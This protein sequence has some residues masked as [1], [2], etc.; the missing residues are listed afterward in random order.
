MADLIQPKTLAASA[1]ILSQSRR[2]HRLHH[3]KRKDNNS[4]I[5]W[6]Q[7]HR[8][9]GPHLERLLCLRQAAGGVGGDL[10]IGEDR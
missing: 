5:N 3:P 8:R 6:V 10:K 9:E 4:S 1:L 7:G 2:I